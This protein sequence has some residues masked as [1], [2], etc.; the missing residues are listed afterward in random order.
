MEISIKIKAMARR[1]ARSPK[2]AIGAKISGVLHGNERILVMNS[3][4]NNIFTCLYLL[5]HVCLTAVS[6]PSEDIVW[7]VVLFLNDRRSPPF[8]QLS[9]QSKDVTV[10]ISK[11]RRL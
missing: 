4:T 7:T 2:M 6:I 3:T 1:A 8:N 10:T 9:C 11:V 5:I